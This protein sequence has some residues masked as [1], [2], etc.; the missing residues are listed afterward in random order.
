MPEVA[1]IEVQAPVQNSD[2]Y[3]CTGQPAPRWPSFVVAVYRELTSGAITAEVRT[4]GS[5]CFQ[6]YDGRV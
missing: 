1:V 5:G 4:Q 2:H 3:P 6:A